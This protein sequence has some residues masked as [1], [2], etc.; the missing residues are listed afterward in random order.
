L[1]PPHIVWAGDENH[2][3]NRDDSAP[4]SN[5]QL[6]T[7]QVVTPTVPLTNAVQQDLTS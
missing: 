5:L 6:P 4:P 1:L 3:R 7:G 2:G